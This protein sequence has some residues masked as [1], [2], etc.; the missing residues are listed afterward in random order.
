MLLSSPLR[1]LVIFF[2]KNERIPEDWVRRFSPAGD[3]DQAVGAA[4]QA[5]IDARPMSWLAPHFADRRALALVAVDLGR[6]MLD[7]LGKRTRAPAKALDFMEAWAT[8]PAAEAPKQGWLALA[9]ALE[10]TSEADSLANHAAMSIG[11]AV[12]VPDYPMAITNVVNAV[13]D[14]KTEELMQAEKGGLKKRRTEEE[15]EEVAGQAG[16]AVLGPM[17][18]HVRRRIPAPDGPTFLD[19]LTKLR[20]KE[21]EQAMASGNPARLQAFRPG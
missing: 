1:D 18:E 9:D 7:Y 4:W 20:G 12:T 3:L 8:S 14:R 5:E 17:A 16:D 21:L 10:P 15:I 11:T 2:R 19:A 13:L 6:M